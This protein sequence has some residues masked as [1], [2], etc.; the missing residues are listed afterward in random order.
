MT[1]V[2]L[3]QIATGGTPPV[4]ISQLNKQV[5]ETKLRDSAQKY[6]SM[7]RDPAQAHRAW[8]VENQATPENRQTYWEI[9]HELNPSD[10]AEALIDRIESD[11]N[12]IPSDEGKS[13]YLRDKLSTLPDYAQEMFGGRLFH[14]ANRAMKQNEFKSKTVF[15]DDYRRQISQVMTTGMLDPDVASSGFM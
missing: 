12:G 9:E 4:D 5:A 14:H 11:L 2:P 8:I 6:K 10:G 3:E 1:L 7:Y 15:R 13:W